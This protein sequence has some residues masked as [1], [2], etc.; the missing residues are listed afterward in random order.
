MASSSSART[1]VIG[2]V[3]GCLEELERLYDTCRPQPGDV[4][5]Q[6][7]DLVAKGP[8]SRGVIRFCREKGILAVLGNHDAAVLRQKDKKQRKDSEHGRVADSLKDADWTYLESLPLFR[9]LPDV[10]AIVVHAGLVPGVALGAQEKEHCLNLRSITPEGKPSKRR[11]E[12]APWAS[13]WKGPAF[14]VFGHD[15]AR[16]LQRHPHALGVD[17]GCVYGRQLTA[18]VLPERA[19]VSVDA[20][21]VYSKPDILA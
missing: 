11:D 13:H 19:L 18:V 8:D 9:E 20:A 15:A 17:T 21:K 16:G 4:V 7:G 12:G 6:V 1:F 10:G 3:H 14:V 2:D 5:I